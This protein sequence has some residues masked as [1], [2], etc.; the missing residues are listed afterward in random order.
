MSFNDLELVLTLTNYEV[1]EKKG[2][3]KEKLKIM[4]VCKLTINNKNV[5]FFQ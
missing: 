4:L 2:S 3:L 1:S 5:Y